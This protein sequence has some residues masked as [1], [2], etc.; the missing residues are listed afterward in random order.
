VILQAP[1]SDRQII[2]SDY[3]HIIPKPSSV[4][5]DLNQFVP[6]EWSSAFYTIAGCTWKRWLSL[7]WKPEEDEINLDKSEDFFSSDLSDHRLENVFEPLE[8]P[9]LVLLSGEDTTYPKAVKEKLPELL[10]RF[11]QAVGDERW[12]PLSGILKGAGH[13][14]EEDE[15]AKVL[16]EKVVAFVRGL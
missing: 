6:A 14:V 3:A 4:P 2:E 13:N 12:S 15:P 5:Q 11:E 7:T 16:V 9:I 1:V 10:G 8:C